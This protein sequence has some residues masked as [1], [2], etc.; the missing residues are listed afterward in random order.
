M[1]VKNVYNGEELANAL[2]VIVATKEH[3][4]IIFHEDLF[5]F[6]EDEIHIEVEVDKFGEYIVTTFDVMSTVTTTPVTRTF[7]SSWNFKDY[8]WAVCG[9]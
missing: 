8:V 1:E 4:K 2:K 7:T 3:T 6:N 5:G 9:W